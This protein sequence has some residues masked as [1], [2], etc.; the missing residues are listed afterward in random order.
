MHTHDWH[1]KNPETRYLQITVVFIQ[2]TVIVV[3]RMAG[4]PHPG[5]NGTK[6]FHL[7]VKFV[8]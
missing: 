3:Q 2:P 4:E 7:E 1:K 5:I 6:Y 8:A